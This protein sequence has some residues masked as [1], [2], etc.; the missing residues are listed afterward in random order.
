[1][2]SMSKTLF[3]C[4][5]VALA[6]GLTLAAAQAFAATPEIPQVQVRYAH[7]PYF[8]HSQAIIGLK[9]GW[10]KEVGITYTPNDVGISVSAEDAPAVFASGRLDVMSSPIGLLMPAAKTLPPFKM[11]FY[12]DIFQGYAIMA[13]PDANA[14]SFQEFLAEGKSPDAAYKATMAQLN[15]K[16]FAFPGEAA[17]K[18]F[19]DIALQKGGLTLADVDAVGA[20]HDPDNVALMQAKR[21]DFQVGGVPSRMTLQ[22]AGFKPILTSGDLASYATASADSAEL[23]AVFHDGWVS[24]DAW[25]NANYETVLRIASV[26]FRIN[27]FI[28]EHPDDAAAIHTPF[29]NSI[30]GTNFE[31]SVAKVAYSGLDPF[32]TFD[33]QSGWIL[34]DKNPLNGKYVIGAAIKIYEEK[35]LFKPGEFTYQNFTIAPKVYKDL[36]DYKAK[37]DDL[38]KKI[39]D[40]PSATA[41]PLVEKAKAFYAGFDFLDAYRFASAAAG[42]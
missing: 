26:G 19:I 8:D 38:F 5:F 1:M 22:I 12:G 36:L 42:G 27:Q 24:T 18:G 35:D 3:Q 11:F 7:L 25:I 10:F 4:R 32:W 2:I 15:G 28:A 40:S 6:A 21:A 14:K 23:R 9:K 29:L 34:D 17:I 39:G 30:A 37:T 16:R 13:Q 41:A 31:N 20:P 33:K